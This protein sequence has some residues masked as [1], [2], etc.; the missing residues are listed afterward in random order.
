MYNQHFKSQNKLSETVEDYI[1]QIMSSLELLADEMV[2]LGEA[3]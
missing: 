3:R 2:D 1:E